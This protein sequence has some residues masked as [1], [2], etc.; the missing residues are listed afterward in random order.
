[1]ETPVE[2][3][4]PPRLTRLERVAAGA[5]LLIG[6]LGLLILGGCF[7]VGVLW[8]VKTP[9]A[10][11]NGPPSLSPSESTLVTALYVLAVLC[12]AGALV[13]LSLAVVGLCRIL[14]EKQVPS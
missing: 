10:V 4:R 13:V 7:L 2:V 12:F 1:M 9:A 5:I 3:A 14:W 6:S 11:P 8:V